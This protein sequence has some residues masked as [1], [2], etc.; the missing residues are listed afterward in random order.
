M[1]ARA[2]CQAEDG[3]DSAAEVVDEGVEVPVV[4]EVVDE[5]E[6]RCA[7]LFQLH[8]LAVLCVG[9]R[10]G[11]LVLPVAQHAD[12]TTTSHGRHAAPAAPISLYLLRS[13]TWWRWSQ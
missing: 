11:D 9:N 2:P 8:L 1:S 13:G 6:V 4:G 7:E 3:E 10:Q 12:A 5:E